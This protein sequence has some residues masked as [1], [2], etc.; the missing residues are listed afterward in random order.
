VKLG[1]KLGAM[2]ALG[3]LASGC[4]FS[5]S[6]TRPVPA[7]LAHA[8]EGATSQCLVV[9]LPGL[10][11]GPDSF[12]EHGMIRQLHESGSPCDAV[13]VDLHYRYFFEGRAGDVLYEDVIDPALARGYEEIWVVG[14]SLGGMG[15]TLLA[16]EHGE[17]LAG[18]I[19]LSPFLGIEPTR[20]EVADAGLRDWHPGPLPSEITDTTFTRFVW[21]Y[22]RGYVDDPEA[23]PPMYVGWAEG[24]TQERP[25]STLAAVLP[26]ERH[27][28]VTGRHDWEA[29]TQL[30]A[31]LVARARPGR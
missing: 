5:R 8:R 20:T 19:L 29:W 2:L 24:E 23:L 21:A 18:I 7:L 6:P 27:V 25:S 26:E 4:Y 11:D 10:L 31:I 15:A 3:L 16:R 1:A 9:F 14:I 13:M 28:T 30:F 17:S 22:L 12:L